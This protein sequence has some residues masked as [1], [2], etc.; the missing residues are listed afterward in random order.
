MYGYYGGYF[1]TPY[2]NLFIFLTFI[3]YF[4]FIFFLYNNTYKTLH[5]LHID[6]KHKIIFDIST[7]KVLYLYGGYG[8]SGGYFPTPYINLLFF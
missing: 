2:I 3:F 5:T 6:I 4:L 1:P 7:E 8:Y